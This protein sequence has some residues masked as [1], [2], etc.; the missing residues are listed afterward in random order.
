MKEEFITWLNE[1]GYT[2]ST[3]EDTIISD[4]SAVELDELYVE[5]I[6]K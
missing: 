2:S 5:F 3:D 6:N 4:L 1:N